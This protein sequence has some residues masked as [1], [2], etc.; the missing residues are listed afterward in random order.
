MCL[1]GFGY[2]LRKVGLVI[3]PMGFV[4]LLDL[5]M[6]LFRMLL[7]AWYV[8]YPKCQHWLASEQGQCHPFPIHPLQA[9]V[10]VAFDVV[11]DSG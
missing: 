2:G 9:V 10:V 8:L 7:P 5:C 4:V 1:I 11:F 6:Q 3:G